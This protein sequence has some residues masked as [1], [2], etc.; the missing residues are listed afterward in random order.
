[1]ALQRRTARA[2]ASPSQNVTFFRTCKLQLTWSET[3]S[4]ALL[5]ELELLTAPQVQAAACASCSSAKADPTEEPEPAGAVHTAGQ[6][7]PADVR[8]HAHHTSTDAADSQ[9]HQ[10]SAA[11]DSAEG[12]QADASTPLQAASP[13]PSEERNTDAAASDSDAQSSAP[14][15]SAASVAQSN[16]A[17]QRAQSQHIPAAGQASARQRIFVANVHLEGHPYRA[18]ERLSQ[19]RSALS[20]LQ[21]QVGRSGLPAEAA[22]VLVVG[23][24]YLC[25]HV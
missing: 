19:A 20:R 24:G 17:T 7:C 1:M 10:S 15:R 18:K 14:H 3:R 9:D 11:V 16:G 25:I 23:A 5:T 22:N 8:A 4:R 6:N 13:A 21:L 12:S 2:S